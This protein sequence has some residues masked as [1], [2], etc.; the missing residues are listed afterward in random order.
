MIKGSYLNSD[1]YNI[2]KDN[3]TKDQ[4]NEIKK[5]LTVVPLTGGYGE[6][7]VEKT[8]FKVYR[9]E[10]DIIKIPRFY[11]TE[12][13]GVPKKILY[14]PEKAKIK[15]TGE[16]RDYQ[17][18]IMDICL[19][20]IRERGGGMLCLPCGAG[21]TCLAIYLASQLNAKT[22]I[23]CTKG[24]LMDQ[25]VAR[26]KQFTKSNVG[27]IRQKTVD[28]EDKDFV[29]GMI[30]SISMRD[31][32]NEIF[33]QFDFLVLD[34]AHHFGAKVF[35]QG[36]S[37]VSCKYT[38]ALSATPHRSDGLIKIVNWY[39]GNV[40]YKQKLKTNNNVVAK[41]ITFISDDKLF[42]EKRRY[43][44]GSMKPNSVKMI[45][46]IIDIESRNKH[47][48]N[49][50]DQLRKDGLRKILILSERKAHLKI[51]KT[52]VDKLIQ[53]DID[54]NIILENE[55]RSYFYTGDCKRPERFEAE[56]FSDLLYGSYALAEE[57]LDIDRLNCIVLAS[58]KKNV[59]QSVGRILRKDS[60][61][62][63]LIIDVT[64]N[65]SIF[66]SQA[67]KRQKFYKDSKYVQQF[68]YMSND[69]LVSP[70]EYLKLI[71][72]P[73]ENSNKNV[74]ADYASM[75]EVPEI[76]IIEDGKIGEPENDEEDKKP[77]KIKKYKDPTTISMF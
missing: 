56:Q 15:F 23:V 4:L 19:P 53:M 18:K 37:K 46:N 29:V 11:G 21:K 1:G 13:F 69:E 48:I 26:I 44:N 20:H 52:E 76:E 72:E 14:K 50:I 32:D 17:Q 55:C 54:A 73:D 62:R 39:I 49:I 47:I 59:V 68:Y 8:K 16:L 28:I 2:P 9:I 51:L 77:K 12:K 30:Q 38:L 6:T 27:T 60:E 40:M 43:I 36:L 24:F 35:S 63:P 25:W 42:K 75:L 7:D 67:L 64:D 41:I 58:P 71:N 61:I 3:I 66:K 74:P 10:D 5:D 33:K 57:G 65:L 22:L 34:E 70:Y 31:Y 45:S